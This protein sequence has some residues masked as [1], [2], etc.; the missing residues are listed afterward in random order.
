MAFLAGS[1]LGLA[2]EIGAAERHVAEV[3][4]A[5]PVG[6]GHADALADGY[7]QAL[8]IAAMPAAVAALVALLFPRRVHVLAEKG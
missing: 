7:G 8:L 1:A 5:L 6:L 4:A 2:F 3:V